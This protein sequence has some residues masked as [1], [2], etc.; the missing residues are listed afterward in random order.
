[1][2]IQESSQSISFEIVP[3]AVFVPQ[4]SRP[5]VGYYF[6]A[7]HITIRNT[8]TTAAQLLSRHWVILDGHNQTEEVK[9]SGVVG[10]Q[11]RILPGQS[12]DYQSACP[13][14]T[15]TGSMRGSFQM[16]TD[17]GENFTIQIPEFY[18]VSPNSLH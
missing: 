7:Y 3:K 17:A 2:A 4:E 1:M 10:L 14:R 11:P 6:F 15:P 8:G 5:E 18:L 13:L 9:G 16:V 12:F